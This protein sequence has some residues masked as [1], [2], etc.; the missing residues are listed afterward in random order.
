MSMGG[1]SM[2]FDEILAQVL[3]LLQREGRVSYRALKR[4][5]NLDQE[6]LDDLKAEIT[7]AK[8][9][10]IDEDNTVLVWTGGAVRAGLGILEA[11]EQLSRRLEQEGS[12]KLAARLG[13]HTG[14]VVVG[15]IG[16]QGR[17]EQLALGEAPNVAA[18]LQG[19][20]APNTMVI[21]AAT[22]RLV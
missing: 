15:E 7:N 18:R 12:I 6:W 2:T 21:S 11:L 10:A 19:F 17:Q 3:V 4:R 16:G 8:Q 9:L 13:I 20:A 14:L 22:H 5:F 1:E